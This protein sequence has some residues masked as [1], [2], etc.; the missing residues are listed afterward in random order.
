MAKTTDYTGKVFGS[1]RIG[2]TVGEGAEAEVF[3][4]EHLVTGRQYI[5]RLDAQDE[6]LWSGKPVIPPFN[7]EIEIKN[8][9]G[10][11]PYATAY[12]RQTLEARRKDKDAWTVTAPAIYGI[13]ADR[14]LVPVASPVRVKRTWDV[15]RLLAAAPADGMYSGILQEVLNY[16]VGTAIVAGHSAQGTS[17]WKGRW[18]TLASGRFLTAA[19]A[20][21]ARSLGLGD[22]QKVV[23]SLIGTPDSGEPEMAENLLVRLCACLAS[24]AMSSVEA[25]A[26]LRDLH[27]RVNVSVRDVQQA[28]D[29]SGILKHFSS[30]N[31]F[32]ILQFVMEGLTRQPADAYDE[33]KIFEVRE[34][35]PELDRYKL[36]LQEYVGLH[37]DVI[38]LAAK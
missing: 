11:W 4:C 36:F 1:F 20:D 15:D 14:Y 18:G 30:K 12:Y 22:Q 27:F 23:L 19:V 37:Q 35:Q 10:A 13:L 38:T 21:Y 26:T 7:S 5:L 9:R 2:E 6:R 34:R 29:L 25:E 16:L 3:R 33:A 24:G 28:V 31:L 32:P 8:A 17:E